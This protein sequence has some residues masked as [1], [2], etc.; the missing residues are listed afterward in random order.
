MDSLLDSLSGRRV[1]GLVG[2]LGGQIF[3]LLLGWFVASVGRPGII[4][5]KGGMLHFHNPVVALV[6]S[7]DV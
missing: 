6:L 3:S 5:W 1:I 7:M 4:F 2:R